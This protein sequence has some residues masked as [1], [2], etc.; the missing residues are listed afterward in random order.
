MIIRTFLPV[1]E[2][3]CPRCGTKV[4]DKHVKIC[5]KCKKPLFF[6]LIKT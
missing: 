2:W 6:D 5:P 1:K 4:R 3:K